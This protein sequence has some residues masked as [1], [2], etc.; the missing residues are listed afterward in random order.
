MPPGNSSAAVSFLS[1]LENADGSFNLTSSREFDSIYSLGPNKPSETALALLAFKAAG[2]PAGDE[3]IQRALSFLRASASE[4]YGGSAYAASLAAITFNAFFPSRFAARGRRFRRRFAFVE[5]FERARH[6]VRRVRV[7]FR[8]LSFADSLAFS[9]PVSK[10][11]SF[12]FAVSFA[13]AYSDAYSNAY[14]HAYAY[15]DADNRNSF[16]DCSRA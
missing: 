4:N 8:A 2:V 1:S 15:S 3:R 7:E 6:G 14:S 13:V 11:G 12:A 10:P 9:F 5:R 16:R